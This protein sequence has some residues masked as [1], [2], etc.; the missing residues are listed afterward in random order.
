MNRA[1]TRPLIVTAIALALVAPILVAGG[2][3]ARTYVA[4]SFYVADAVRSARSGSSD[5][6]A[7][8]LD[9]ET[10]VRGFALTG[11]PSDARRT[12]RAPSG[13]ATRGRQGR[14]RV[15]G[16]TPRRELPVLT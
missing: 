10:A 7:A 12:R 14:P 1:P 13:P 4:A 9:E 5:M 2:V 16:G 8:Q 15:C 3:R 11:G 6:I